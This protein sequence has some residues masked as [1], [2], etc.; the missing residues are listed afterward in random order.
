MYFADNWLIQGAEVH[1]CFEVT[2]SNMSCFVCVC[3]TK[4]PIQM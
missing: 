3:K 4:K 2:E 1:V